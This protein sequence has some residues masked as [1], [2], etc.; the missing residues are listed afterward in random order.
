MKKVTI[1]VFFKE[2]SKKL[3]LNTEIIQKDIFELKI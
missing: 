3:R 1:N 2:V